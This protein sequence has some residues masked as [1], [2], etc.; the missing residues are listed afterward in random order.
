MWKYKIFRRGV[1]AADE[2]VKFMNENSLTPE[3]VMI[4]Q[5]PDVHAYYIRL[6]YYVKSE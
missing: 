6:F 1:Y 2:L 5:E 3:N 4:V